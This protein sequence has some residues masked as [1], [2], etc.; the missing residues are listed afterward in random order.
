MKPSL[1]TGRATTFRSIL[2]LILAILAST[3]MWFYVNH[4]LV[5]HQIQDSLVSHTPRGNLS[6]LYPR[7]LG[8]RE[9][10]LRGRNPYSPEISAEIQT[11][12]YGRPLDPARADDPKDVQAFAYPVYVV[13]LLAPLVRLPFHAVQFVFY[14]M[15]VLLSAVS[16][17]LWLR[18]LSWRP[19]C[20]AICSSMVLFLGSIP[21]VQGIKLQQLTL[22]VA[23][24]LAASAAAIVG[25][26]LALGGILLALATI[27][28]QLA[29]PLVLW[30]LVWTA[31]D[32]RARRNLVIA[33]TAAMVLLLV[34]SEIFL[35]GWIRMFLHAIRQYRM[36]TSSQ[37]VLDVSAG[38]FL[39][40]A[41]SALAVFACARRLWTLRSCPSG[42][43]A[44]GYALALVMALAVLVVPMIGPYNQV[45]LLPVVLEMLRGFAAN[46]ARSRAFRFA[47]TA[48]AA[49][50]ALPWIASLGLVAVYFLFSPALAMAAWKLPFAS[51]ITLP[52][53]IFAL[54]IFRKPPTLLADPQAGSVV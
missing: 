29:W 41:L 49:A 28:P 44:F 33:F 34:G 13:F 39:G 26:Q 22:V 53:L 36:Y 25:G 21:A 38:P 48:C 45:L 43:A 8:A 11:G 30:F 35:P 19:S 37:S 14:W 54:A 23:P 46:A 31:G 32:W 17:L 9:L 52:I 40:P 1:D 12:Y 42:S 15:L 24:L 3:S 10:L 7:W 27:K 4:I 20:V 16:V 47:A 50:S 2:A 51:T 5:A 6:D 18:A